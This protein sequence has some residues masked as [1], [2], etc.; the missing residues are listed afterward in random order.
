MQVRSP[1]LPKPRL[2]PVAPLCSGYIHHPSLHLPLSPSTELLE[3]N[4]RSKGFTCIPKGL[5][6]VQALGQLSVSTE[7]MRGWMDEWT[8]GM[9]QLA[10]YTSE[11]VEFWEM[12]SLATI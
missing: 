5:G 10:C 2:R 7:R 11:H 6:Q 12:L 1:L 8:Q 3:G 4:A 9:N